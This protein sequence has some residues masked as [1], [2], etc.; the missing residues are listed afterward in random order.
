MSRGMDFDAGWI[1]DDLG[2]RNGVFFS[3]AMYRE[4]L[5]PAHK[6][7]CDFF[8]RRGKRMLMHS[9]GNVKALIPILIEMG[10]DCLQPLEVKAGMDVVALKRDFG[11]RLALFGGIDARAMA[12]SD[13]RIIEHEIAAKVPLAKRGGGYLFHSDHSIPDN[14]SF[15]QYCR[16]M[17]LAQRYGKF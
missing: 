1:A 2:Y 6:L 5:M 13:P 12:E 8:K 15:A 14:V 7:I 3:P 16:V 17:E 4:L 9:D 10:V 11:D